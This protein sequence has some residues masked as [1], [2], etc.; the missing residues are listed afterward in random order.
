MARAYCTTDRNID[1][2]T[3]RFDKRIEIER[4]RGGTEKTKDQVEADLIC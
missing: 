1:G 4:G 3:T 2:V